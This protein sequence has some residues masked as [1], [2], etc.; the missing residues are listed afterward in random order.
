VVTVLDANAI[1]ALLLEEPAAEDVESLLEAPDAAPKLSA[2]NLG[3]VVDRIVRLRRMS[4]D[5]VIER[6]TW[7][8]A[9]GLEIADADL[10]IGAVAGFLRARHYRRRNQD[11]SIADCYAL[12]TASV[13]EESLATSDQAVAAVARYEEIELVP[14][15][16]STGRRPI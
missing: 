4:F 14:L 15:P 12:A 2:I 9:G 6:L 8:A 7:L 11:I 13:L 16:D 10:E 5:D 1:I 3:E